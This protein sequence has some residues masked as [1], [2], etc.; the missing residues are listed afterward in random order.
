M[1]P[2]ISAPIRRELYQISFTPVHG[3]GTGRQRRPEPPPIAH[4]QSRF[5]ITRLVKFGG[6]GESQTLQNPFLRASY[7]GFAAVAGAKRGDFG[8]KLPPQTPPP[9]KSC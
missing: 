7:G 5:D 6:F 3:S 8:E 9:C 4:D 2:A 1:Q